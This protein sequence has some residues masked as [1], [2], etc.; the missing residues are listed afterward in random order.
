M[1]VADEVTR[2]WNVERGAVRCKEPRPDLD[3]E[4]DSITGMKRRVEILEISTAAAERRLAQLGR[5]ESSD[6]RG[7]QRVHV[8]QRTVVAPTSGLGLAGALERAADRDGDCAGLTVSI[9][10]FRDVVKSL[11]RKRDRRASSSPS[12]G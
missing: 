2:R 12:A 4:D 9:D 6:R 7:R 5:I 3:P 10:T 11:L 1:P 8:R